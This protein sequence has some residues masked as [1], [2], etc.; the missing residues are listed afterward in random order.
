MGPPQGLIAGRAVSTAA[1][2]AEAQS[3]NSNPA[4][5]SVLELPCREIVHMPRAVYEKIRS[6]GRLSLNAPNQV[7]AARSWAR[8]VA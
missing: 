2:A 5:A 4:C 6:V 1:A 3:G 7:V 8:L